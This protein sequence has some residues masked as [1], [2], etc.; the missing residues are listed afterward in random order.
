MKGVFDGRRGH[1]SVSTHKAI[2]NAVPSVLRKIAAVHG[3]RTSAPCLER[4]KLRDEVVFPRMETVEAEIDLCASVGSWTKYRARGYGNRGGE[5]W[6]QVS[7]W[8]LY[9]WPW[10]LI[11]GGLQISHKAH[12]PLPTIPAYKHRKGLSL[13]NVWCLS[14]R[15][16]VYKLMT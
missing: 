4:R 14:F 2:G 5:R 16:K 11:L 10:I 12:D 9:I 3:I 15:R 13:L 7:T 6:G 1:C 8:K